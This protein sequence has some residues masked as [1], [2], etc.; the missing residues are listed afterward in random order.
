[1]ERFVKELADY[2]GN[3]DNS[4][5][6]KEEVIAYLSKVR[7]RILRCYDRSSIT[8]VEAAQA[9]LNTVYPSKDMYAIPVRYPESDRPDWVD[10]VMFHMPH[11]T[12]S[13]INLHQEILEFY[14]QHDPE[15]A[16]RLTRIE[17]SF[18]MVANKYG[19]T[20]RYLEQSVQPLE[21]E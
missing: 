14:Q 8:A 7:E 18:D 10:V 3:L 4:S 17:S 16:D 15:E 2:L 11:N 5:L 13:N 20:W 6:M 12:P 9:L 21:V 1:M 19:G